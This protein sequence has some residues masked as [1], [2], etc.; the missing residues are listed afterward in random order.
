MEDSR[1]RKISP[2]DKQKLEQSGGQRLPVRVKQRLEAEM[3]VKLDDVRIHTDFNAQQIANKVGA[4][5]FAVGNHIV[6]APGKYQP[7]TPAGKQLLAH[8]LTHVIQQRS[9]K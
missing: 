4:Q 9:G 1:H 5:A 7:D 3:R 8:E 6:F 2:V